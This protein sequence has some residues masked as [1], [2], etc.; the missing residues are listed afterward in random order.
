MDDRTNTKKITLVDRFIPLAAKA[1]VFNHLEDGS[2]L[3][4]SHITSDDNTPVGGIV[5]RKTG[6]NL[7]EEPG[8]AHK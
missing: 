6:F 5:G 2:R 1:A 3:P 7:P 8:T 4:C